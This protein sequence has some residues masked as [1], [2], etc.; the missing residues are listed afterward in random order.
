MAPQSFPAMA[1]LPLYIL[2]ATVGSVLAFQFI[3]RTVRD[4]LV[5]KYASVDDIKGLSQ[6]RPE[7]SK[8]RGTAVVCGGSYAGLATA[9]VLHDHFERVVIIEPEEWLLGYDARRVDS[10]SQEGKRARIIQYMSLQTTQ[11][12]VLNA[13]RYMFPDWDATCKESDIRIAPFSLNYSWAG[14]TP[15]EPK[16]FFGGSIPDSMFATRRGLETA[17]RRRVLDSKSYPNITQ[18]A[19]QVTNFIVDE[20][21]SN[22]VAGVTYRAMGSG[23]DTREHHIYAELVVD[24]TGTAQSS[25]KW[26]SRAGFNTE[27]P[28]DTYDPKMRYTTFTFKI[29]P[30][31][32]AKLPVP[33]GFHRPSGGYIVSL[34]DA[35]ND[36]KGLC[37]V[38]N[39]GNLLSVCPGGWGTTNGPL[40]KDVDDIMAHCN[41]L[42]LD[43]PLPKWVLDTIDM[44]HEV[45]DDMYVSQVNVG[46]SFLM[47][48]EKCKGLPTNYVAL[49][50]VV[51]RV[52]PL[53]GHGFAKALT[54]A[55]CLNTILNRTRTSTT[56]PTTFGNDFFKL[57]ANKIVPMWELPI[58]IDYGQK[59][60]IP[61]AGEKKSSTDGLRWYL[62]KVIELSFS[63]ESAFVPTYL[64]I[65][66]LGG[67][68]I[69][70]LHPVLAAK[71]AWR[72]L[73]GATHA[74]TAV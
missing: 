58:L 55:T 42:K 44:L 3:W 20:K 40:M 64:A 38:R 19:G 11:P 30:E 7:G 39:E 74:S 69:D 32:A 72:H 14:R 70:L 52:N 27:I 43:V 47:K 22:R 18:I 9:R 71:V 49:G 59:S 29:T 66:L 61:V 8:V 63:D 34:P 6:A 24:C 37:I 65:T 1:S 62:S 57:H 13:L 36:N 17:L 28:K 56:L 54:G 12:F 51:C 4:H 45:E 23:P 41:S 67:A 31:L 35:K 48:F 46:P 73:S 33:G 21:A 16:N 15:K 68:S 53:Y 60:T 5:S 50:D 26:L 10:W 25:L 2:P